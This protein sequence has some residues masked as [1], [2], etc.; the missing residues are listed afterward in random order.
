V[1]SRIRIP[2]GGEV[3][4]WVHYHRIHFQ[5][6]FCAAGWVDVVYEDQGE[7]FRLEAGDCVLQPPEIRH[8]VL[9]SSPG[10]EVIEMACPAVHDTISDHELVLPT[11]DV[12]PWRDFGGQRFLRH[13]A[14]GAPVVDWLVD[15][16]VAR[17]TGVGA[18]SGGIA[19]AVVVRAGVG[20]TRRTWLTHDGELVFDV[21]LAGSADLALDVDGGSRTVTLGRGDAVA[22]PPGA[23]WCWN[24]WSSDIEL[25]E[26]AVGAGAVQTV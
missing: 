14:A 5:L 2:D 15:G 1:A 10:V 23:R 6:I 25:L 19:G 22:L 17:D 11:A 8:R 21:V 4:D 18:A 9:R 3:A 24:A 20:A 26:V 7:P 13:V 16:L 12:R